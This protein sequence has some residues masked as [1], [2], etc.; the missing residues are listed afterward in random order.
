MKKPNG[1]LM[2]LPIFG[3]A[4]GGAMYAGLTAAGAQG[5]PGGTYVPSG[6]PARPHGPGSFR[7]MLGLLLLLGGGLFA[8]FAFMYFCDTFSIARRE[9][10]VATGAELCRKHYIKAAPAWIA[11]TFAESKPTTLTVTRRRLGLGGEVQARCLLVRAEDKWLA[12]IVPDSFDSNQLVGYIP[13]VDSPSTK[14]LLQQVRKAEPGLALLPYEFSAVDGSV[15]DQQLRFTAA[16]VMIFL[17]LTGLL[18]GFL[19]VRRRRP[20]QATSLAPT[21][22]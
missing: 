6:S 10:R 20:A 7:W 19:L 2:M 15:S 17:G 13:P 21:A 3:G 16:G 4:I 9:P 1:M 14:S 11:Y 22:A 8:V 12:A 5:S 18:L